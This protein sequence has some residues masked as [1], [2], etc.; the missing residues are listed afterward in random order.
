[1][2]KNKIIKLISILLITGSLAFFSQL[3]LN[4]LTKASP[5][6]N[7]Q[8]RR[9]IHIDNTTNNNAL[10]DY[11]VMVTIDTA[12]L[13]S[14]S[15]M[16]SN[17]DDIRF[18]DSNNSTN[19]NYWIETGNSNSC[20]STNT[21]IWVK[22]PNINANSRKTIYMYYGDNS[23]A[24]GSSGEDTFIFFDEF[25]SFNATKW[26]STNGTNGY[27]ISGGAITINSGA[28]YTNSTIGNQPGQMVEAQMRWLNTGL[29]S[30]LMIA[31]QQNTHSGNSSGAALSYIL[32]GA[33]PNFDIY[34]YGL[35]ASGSSGSYDIAGAGNILNITFNQNTKYIVGTSLDS[36]NLRFFI[37][38]SNPQTS[39][40]STWSSSQNYYLWL[41]Y[42]MGGNSGTTDISDIEV[43]WVLVRK[44]TSS[45]PSVSVGAETISNPKYSLRF[46][47]NGVNAP[48][49]DRVKIALDNPERP[50]DVA[51]NFT[52]E[53]WMKAS[54][55]NNQS[56]TCS[57]G[58][59]TNWINGNI[60]FD[61][62]IYG[63]GDYGDW[64]I[65]LYG[66]VISFGVSV[67]S[68]DR[69]ICGAT[70]VANNQW[71]H[72]AVTRNSSTGEMR[73]FVNG[74]QDA[75]GTG[76]TG[77]ISY[78][79]NRTTSY[80]NSD[81]YLVIGAEKH[82]AGS[83]YPSYNGY[84]DEVR[85]SN[86]VRYTS[87]FTPPSHPFAPD[88]NTLALYHF[89][90]GQ[91]TTAHDTSGAQTGP[92]DGIL[93]V[94]GNPTGPIWSTDQPFAETTP[95]N[96]P[97]P[98]PTPT[99][100]PTPT[101]TPTPYPNNYYHVLLSGQSLATGYDGAPPLSTSQPYNN[102]KLNQS[103]NAFVPLIENE[104]VND[105]LPNTPVE[106]PASA[107]GNTIT[108]LT[109]GTRRMVVTR[110]AIP[111]ATYAQLKKNGTTS[112][113]AD[114]LTQITNA[115]SIANGLGYGLIVPAV[116]LIHGPANFADGLAY[117]SMLNEWQSDYNTDI[118]QITGQTGNIPM[119]IDQSSNFTAYNY[120]SSDLVQA[121]YLAAKQNPNIYM[122]GPRYHFTYASDNIHIP[123]TGYRWL[124]EYYGKAIS[125]VLNGQTIT[126]LTPAEVVRRNNVITT[127][128][129]VP[130]P[131]LVFDTT[132]VLPRANYGFEYT[133]NGTPPS[134]SSIQ[135]LGNDS[136]RITLSSTPTGS[137]QRLR[138]AFTG[139]AGARPG[140]DSTGSARGNLRDSDN[141]ISLYGN[142]LYNW[143]VHFEESITLDE[144]A[145]NFVTNP[146]FSPNTSGF[147]ATWTT[148]EP[149]SSQILYG[150][151]NTNQSNTETNISPRVT[152]HTSSVSSLL[153]CATY[154]LRARSEDLAGNSAL[155]QETQSTTTGCL[156]NSLVEN[157]TT[158]IAPT[159]SNTNLE[160]K[161]NNL[162]IQISIPAN[163]N[164]T[165]A[166]FQ[167]HKLN[168]NSVINATGSPTEKS[169]LNYFY[170]L[171]AL[172]SE[173]TEITNFSSNINVTITYQDG[174]LGNIESESSL[175]I[176][177][178][179]GSAWSN[180]QNCN[181]NQQT[182]T[183]ICSTNQFSVFG[184]F[185][186]TKNES[187]QQSNSSQTVS[188]SNSATICTSERPSGNPVW[189]FGALQS[190]RN[191]LLLHFVPNS[192]P[193][194][195]MALVYG[196]E[197]NKYTFGAHF[198]ANES[199]YTFNVGNLNPRLNYY[200]RLLPINNCM[201]GEWS[202]ELRA[203]LTQN[204]AT[205]KPDQVSESS[206]RNDS[207]PQYSK[208][209]DKSK[210]NPSSSR[211]TDTKDDKNITTVTP[212]TKI[213]SLNENNQLSQEKKDFQN[214]N[215]IIAIGV[216]LLAFI[217]GLI[218]AIK[219]FLS[220]K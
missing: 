175:S 20:N 199:T 97:T 86:I 51:Q 108:A 177:R 180:L 194:N 74:N 56:P 3:I 115:K 150:L 27:S 197:P 28:V 6:G 40:Y 118:K 176:Y 114:G 71:H 173:S 140:A 70:N 11:Q 132:N 47:G 211:F 41:G 131:P 78:R 88:S 95:T 134:I 152:N 42:F 45:A 58:A 39:T 172:T 57:G 154:T 75:I 8:Y 80:P 184:L 14:Q 149:S 155:G 54:S 164:L 46:Y 160:L 98:T 90:E 29:Q 169:P 53:F 218:W 204:F 55:S 217:I 91:G 19:L 208:D 205:T 185:G 119:F 198:N 147:T 133:D 128:F 5:P 24:A 213:H 210:S 123:N 34:L 167:I 195:K 143:S 171:K 111:G 121:Q 153:P 151:T 32:R 61:R 130:H 138:Y 120:S 62:D 141:T 196:T 139:T 145:P 69:T 209:T 220:K 105:N 31:N 137:N 100:T 129:N 142:N 79:N 22:I 158:A 64:G 104:D 10:T 207:F 26:S 110:N 162:G 202:N 4:H 50:V 190:G 38:R 37:N 219:T 125:R 72:I 113:Y 35:A 124:G 52:L 16:K 33:P 174:D 214:R 65:S 84:V 73:I 92:S 77:N 166:Q 156:G 67:G 189:L 30:G 168:K 136:V 82:D 178:W 36:S 109:G 161:Q 192:K 179:T 66:G 43:D 18:L 148:N 102:V 101:P 165:Q 21:R 188:S 127:R 206:S 12:S 157:Y 44:Y 203:R 216:V 2:Q 170:D 144:T 116:A 13:I 68:N 25:N 7:T 122:I 48:D 146:V 135:L 83:S 183:V 182:N 106:T 76:P 15:K 99:A 89:D 94:G 215:Y 186:K 159:N 63:N 117:Q 103:Q 87:N 81:P 60:I 112:A 200:F 23:L 17:C 181:V 201:P 49:L 93:N 212:T 96:T 187:S 193:F 1:M 107:L 59:N 163:Y 85:I 191:S 126:A 9:M